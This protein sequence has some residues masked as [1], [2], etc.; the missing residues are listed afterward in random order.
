MKAVLAQRTWPRSLVLPITLPNPDRGSFTGFVGVQNRE[1]AFL[2]WS[3][4]SHSWDSTDDWMFLV[5]PNSCFG[6]RILLMPQMSRFERGNVVGGTQRSTPV[7]V[8]TAFP[9][10]GAPEMDQEVDPFPGP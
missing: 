10:Q 3:S 7:S 2:K 4:K 1:A 6:K 8:Q 9:Q 5:L